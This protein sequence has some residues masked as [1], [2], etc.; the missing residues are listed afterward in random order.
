MMLALTG[1][2]ALALAIWFYLLTAHGRFWHVVTPLD[3]EPSS[4]DDWPSVAAVIPARDEAETIAR[5]LGSVLSQDYPGPFTVYLVDDSS[6]DGTAE[7]AARA[8]EE[9]GLSE[10]L[11]VVTARPPATGW[12]GKLWALSEGLRA[13]TDSPEE[14]MHLWFTDADIAHDPSTLRRLVAAAEAEDRDLVSLMVMLTCGTAWEKL[15]IPPFVF[16]FGMLYPFRWIADPRSGTAGAAG[17]CLM[18][19]AEALERSGGIPAMRDALI[20]DCT[21]AE[22][23]KRLGRPGG[24]RLRLALTRRSHSIRPY[25]SLAEI[26]RMVARSAYTQ[27]RYSPVLLLGTLLGMALTYLAPPLLVL[28]YPLHGQPLAAGLGAASWGLMAALFLPTLRLY[29]Q[30]WPMAFALPVAAL[31][32]A[33]MTADSAR[34]HA[35]GRGGLWKGRVQA[36]KSGGASKPPGAAS[37]PH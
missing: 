31:F 30:P 7:I 19:R 32:Y 23:I 37:N 28:T 18:V 15:L 17:G 21:L 34:R 10:R 26:W 33:A 16:F 25:P 6:E 36:P 9:T 3:G 8:A 35:M 12:A 4:R 14:P 22:R 24:G 27:L 1:L 29:G 13:V 5:A 20:D 11:T 2:G